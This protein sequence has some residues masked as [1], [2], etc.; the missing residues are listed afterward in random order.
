MSPL[1]SANRPFRPK[2]DDERAPVASVLLVDDDHFL[3]G[4]IK[5]WLVDEPIHLLVASNG[6]QA[7][8]LLHRRS[9]RLV[10]ADYRLPGMNGRRLLDAVQER[11]PDCKRIL[12]TGYADAD[13]VL[14]ARAHQV[15]SKEL[16]P[17]LI[18]RIIVRAATR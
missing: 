15:I 4:L 2:T 3:L 18:K 12:L 16:D 9:V 13:L 6:L 1:A 5:R 17:S 7:L 8:D 14:E 10:V 11:W